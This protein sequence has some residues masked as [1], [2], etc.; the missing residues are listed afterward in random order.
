MLANMHLEVD[1]AENGLVAVD[2]VT[3]NDYD[4]VLMDIQMPV[5]DG[6]M[7]CEKLKQT[8]ISIPIIAFTANVMEH[9]VSEYSRIGFDGVLAKPV[10]MSKLFGILKQHL[11]DD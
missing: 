9:E 4:L 11:L 1:I 5:M 10:E 3:A 2:K 7:A 6:K 8:G